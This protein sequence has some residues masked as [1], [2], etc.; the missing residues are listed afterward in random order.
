HGRAGPSRAC[1]GRGADWQNPADCA[2][3]TPHGPRDHGLWGYAPRG[4]ALPYQAPNTPDRAASPVEGSAPAL[5]P[6]RRA[7]RPRAW[8]A[9]R[10]LG[11]RSGRLG[12]GSLFRAILLRSTC[13]LPGLAC[14]GCELARALGLAFGLFQALAR[15]LELIF[16]D[17]YTLLG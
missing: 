2:G 6:P 16:G 13:T 4:S 1:R 7:S 8:F 15:A 11:T 9:S 3:A 5:G 10:P 17:T 14:D 12:P